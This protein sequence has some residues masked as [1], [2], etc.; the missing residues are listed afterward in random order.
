MIRMALNLDYYP[1]Q[2]VPSMETHLGTTLPL[3]LLELS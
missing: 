2:R 3:D 1:E